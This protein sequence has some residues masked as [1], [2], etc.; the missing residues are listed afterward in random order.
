MEN[1]ELST[2][3]HEH[4]CDNCIFLGNYLWEHDNIDYDIYICIRKNSRYKSFIAR[5][6]INGDYM[7]A[8]FNVMFFEIG[9]PI[10]VSYERAIQKGLIKREDTIQ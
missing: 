8:S 1:L 2:P 6:G 4:D 9:H 3:K 5:Y 7:S 10:R